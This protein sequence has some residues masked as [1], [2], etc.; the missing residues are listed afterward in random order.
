MT[1]VNVLDHKTT[2]TSVLK[3]NVQQYLQNSVTFAFR[4]MNPRITVSRLYNSNNPVYTLQYIF[5]LRSK[6]KEYLLK[7]KTRVKPTFFI[8]V[9][10]R[11]SE[12][13]N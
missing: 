9:H 3:E 12:Q 2:S 8:I 13:Q 10:V 6:N 5:L 1:S 7:V 4:F 11:T